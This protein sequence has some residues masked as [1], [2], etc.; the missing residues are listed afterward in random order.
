MSRGERSRENKHARRDAAIVAARVGGETLAAIGARFGLSKQRVGQ[1]LDREVGP[2][3]REA[4]GLA[5][6][7]RR[8]AVVAANQD[9]ILA[10]FRAGEELPA[11]ARAVGVER[12][13]VRALI[14][15]EAGAEDR[16]ARRHARRPPARRPRFSEEQLLEAIREAY[17]RAGGAVDQQ[18][19]VAIARELGLPSR[20]TIVMRLG[21]WNAAVEAA[22]LHPKTSRTRA[23]P[24][25]WT[26]E[27]CL[28]ALRELA[29]ELGELPSAARYRQLLREREGLPSPTTVRLRLGEWPALALRVASEQ[30]DR[31]EGRVAA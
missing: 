22:G 27:S 28:R 1:I 29:E 15:A 21:G 8:A 20:A 26:E 14:D 18:R 2:Q 3:L 17:R 5:R 25:R 30:V 11:I 13:E 12:A 19:Y 6:R 23:Y 31:P 16:A 4:L 10:A 9:R 7:R 24:R